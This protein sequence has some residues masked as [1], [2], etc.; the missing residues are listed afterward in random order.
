M[1]SALQSEIRDLLKPLCR[2][3]FVTTA[4]RRGKYQMAPKGFPDIIA[5]SIR[6]KM[7]FIEVKRPKEPASVEQTDFIS[8]HQ[9]NGYCA[10][11][12]RSKDDVIKALTQAKIIN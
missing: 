10:V 2:W 8:W 5:M 7:I 4:G 12:A 1:A 11:I 3:V 9:A 6:G